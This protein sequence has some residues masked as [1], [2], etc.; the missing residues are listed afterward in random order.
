MLCQPL[1]CLGPGRMA[2]LVRALPSHGRGHR[3][4][5][6]YAHQ[7]KAQVN[8]S[9]IEQGRLLGHPSLPAVAARPDATPAQVA[10]AWVLRHDGVVTVPK[11]GTP[12]HVRENCGA[13]ELQLTDEDLG[14]L[15]VAFPPPRGPQPLEML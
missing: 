15:D 10:L 7:V 8:C 1:R 13:L 12:E 4:E 2:Q 5:S 14:E 11:A 6:C 9:P 3:F